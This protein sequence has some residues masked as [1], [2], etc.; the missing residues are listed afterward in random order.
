MGGTLDME[1]TG[2]SGSICRLRLRLIPPVPPMGQ[3][4]EKR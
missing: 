1:S 4:K 3:G 2:P